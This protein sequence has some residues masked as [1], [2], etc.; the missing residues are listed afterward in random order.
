MRHRQKLQ[1]NPI[2]RHRFPILYPPNNPIPMRTT[3]QTWYN[4]MP[5]KTK[6]SNK[7]D[8][9]PTYPNTAT[10]LSIRINYRKIT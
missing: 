1:N 5:S 8:R 3:L 2:H 6:T 7:Y 10:H 4:L 9:N